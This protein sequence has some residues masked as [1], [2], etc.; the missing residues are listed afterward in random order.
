[1]S[2]ISDRLEYWRALAGGADI[3]PIETSRALSDAADTVEMLSEKLRRIVHCRD[4]IYWQNQE[5]G[6]VEVPICERLTA[7]HNYG[8]DETKMKLAGDDRWFVAGAGDYC[9]FGKRREAKQ[10]REWEVDGA[11]SLSDEHI[12]GIEVAKPRVVIDADGREA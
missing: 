2:I 3:Y 9:S 7:K 8:H 12:D 4:C 1:M 6:V 10:C 11:G 5:Q